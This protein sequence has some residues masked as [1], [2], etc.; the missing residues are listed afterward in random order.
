M[1]GEHKR[2]SLG[3]LID[4]HSAYADLLDEHELTELMPH[5]T[6]HPDHDH[7][8]IRRYELNDPNLPAL[9]PR[10]RPPRPDLIITW[11]REANEIRAITSTGETSGAYHDLIL[12]CID[13][14]RDLDHLI[15]MLAPTVD[16]R[17]ARAAQA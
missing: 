8:A 12:R 7:L 14:P 15:E 17:D 6:P 13:D 2:P 10:A 9:D 3:R 11:D 4:D 5:V 16:A 1:P